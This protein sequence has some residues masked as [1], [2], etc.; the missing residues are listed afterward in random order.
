MSQTND[1]NLDESSMDEELKEYIAQFTKNSNVQADYPADNDIS[2][3][4]AEN[5][6]IAAES[7]LLMPASTKLNKILKLK[8]YTLSTIPFDQ[9]DIENRTVS[10]FIVDNWAESL[11]IAVSDILQRQD[12][13][14][15]AVVDSNTSFR[16]EALS[17]ELLMARLS[18]FQEKYL[19]LEK[20]E[21]FL[22]NEKHIVDE[23]Y[24]ELL[25]THKL[26]QSE[27]K[28]QSKQFDIKIQV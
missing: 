13:S 8:G 11:Y 2:A 5:I 14:M 28:S 25:K 17:S 20:K 16:K 4:M 9:I 19:E 27:I 3:I 26:L 22:V 7:D 6:N 18:D 23:K 1:T 10:L 15:S 24:A 21:K 12:R